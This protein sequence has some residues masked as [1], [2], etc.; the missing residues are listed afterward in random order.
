MKSSMIAGAAAAIILSLLAVIHIYWALGGTLGKSRAI[1]TRDGQQLFTPTPFTTFLVAFGLFVMSA[2]NAIRIGW[3]TVPEISRFVR[4]GLW[5]TAAI[6]LLRAVGDF[7][8]V[9]FFKRH[10]ESRFAKLDTLLYSPLC[11]LLACLVAISAD[12]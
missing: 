6:F 2:L 4:A 3:I 9:G 7:R 12:S 1:P 5:L 11:L 10:G 8:Y